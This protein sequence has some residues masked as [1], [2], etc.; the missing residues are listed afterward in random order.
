MATFTE[1][2][3]IKKLI[4]LENDYSIGAHPNV[5]KWLS[6][7]NDLRTTAYGGDRFC[8]M[9]ANKIKTLCHTRRVAVHFFTGG[10][11]VNVTLLASALR[12]YQGIIAASV[13]HIQTH[14]TGAIEAHGYKVLTVPSLDGKVS[15]EE[16]RRL[17]DA[18]Y[19]DPDHEHTVQPGIVSLANPTEY[20]AIYSLEELTAI[21]DVCRKCGLY[22]YVDGARL[23]Y[24]LM[25]EGN[26]ITLADMASLCDAFTI[27]GTKQGAL[28]GEALV[29][30]NDKLK[31]DFRY[32]IKQN[33]AL[34]AKGRLLGL[35]FLGLLEDDIYF[36]TSQEANR[37]AMR[38][39][40]GIAARGY[41]FLLDSPTNQQFP[42]LPDRVIS[43]LSEKYVFSYIK[44]I[45]EEHSC[46]RI[47]T[48]WATLEETVD[49][50]LAD[51]DKAGDP[52]TQRISS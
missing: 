32:M 19:T 47:C 18:H 49:G 3:P 12:P 45:D 25:A 4:H 26:D 44:R 42:I 30:A 11:I 13:A 10:T 39:K 29:I 15:A 52:L 31:K 48:D 6:E 23:G 5:M 1:P 7:T 40:E 50:L 35:N 43:L 46:I 33:G 51:L 16:I 28:F 41:P 9:A 8:E 22:L 20:G 34:L 2:R 24:A 14:E 17:F 21:S 37:L 38:L 36:T 27:G